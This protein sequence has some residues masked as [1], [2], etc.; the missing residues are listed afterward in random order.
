MKQ[1]GLNQY[2]GGLNTQQP[3]TDTP[4]VPFVQESL[5]NLQHELEVLENTIRELFQKIEPICSHNRPEDSLDNNKM[6]PRAI[7]T[8]ISDRIDDYINKIKELRADVEIINS[9]VEI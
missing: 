4:R 3:L 5:S 8:S 2:P 9:S 6:P 1:Q 7:R